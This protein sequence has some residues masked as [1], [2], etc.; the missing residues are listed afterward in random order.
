MITDET[1]TL[2]YYLIQVNNTTLYR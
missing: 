1:I 2:F